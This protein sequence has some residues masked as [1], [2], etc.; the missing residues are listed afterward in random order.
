[1][2]APFDNDGIVRRGWCQ[3][4]VL[5]ALLSETARSYA[6]KAISIGEADRFVVMSHDCDVV[7]VSLD[8]EPWV[9]VLRARVNKLPL[10]KQQS[11]GRNPRILQLEVTFEDEPIVASFSVHDRWLVPRD[12][13][14]LE[15]PSASLGDKQRR[16]IAEW[17]AKRY[18]RAAFP[19]A[20][21]SRWRL[22]FK[23]WQNLLKANS[24]SILGVYLKLSTLAELRYDTPYNCELLLA[25]PDELRTTEGWVKRRAELEKDILKFWEQF[26]PSIECREVTVRAT[27]EI[28]LTDLSEYQ[29][30]D[31]DWVSFEDDTDAIPIAADIRD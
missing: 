7:N 30:F 10:D 14:A 24:K 2:N 8:K 11:S 15:A 21:D 25:V 3:G 27:D 16:L 19:T 23:Q 26:T 20:F 31:I 5:G 12:V 17:L 4:A 13:L 6:P 18:I 28:T 29:R 9:E 22:K 1:M